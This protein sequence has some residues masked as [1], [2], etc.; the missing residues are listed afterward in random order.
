M[1]IGVVGCFHL[2]ALVH[3]ASA[4]TCVQV[5]VGM[6]LALLLEYLKLDRLAHLGDY[7]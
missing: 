3:N 7:Y 1:A 6:L 4:N 2:L 5:F